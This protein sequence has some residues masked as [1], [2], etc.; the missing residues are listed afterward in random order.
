MA[1]HTLP[2]ALIT[3]GMRINF[4]T[5]LLSLI[6]RFQLFSILDAAREWRRE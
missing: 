4:V 6:F 1:W 2:V 3:A 5:S